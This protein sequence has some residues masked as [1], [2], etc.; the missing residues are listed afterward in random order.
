MAITVI[1]GLVTSTVLTLFVVPVMYSLF[2][3]RPRPAA[4]AAPMIARE[5]A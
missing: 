4:A 5:P 2:E 3:R 1:G